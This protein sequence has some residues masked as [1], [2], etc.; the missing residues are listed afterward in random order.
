MPQIQSKTNIYGGII[1]RGRFSG[2]EN[3]LKFKSRLRVA[4]TLVSQHNYVISPTATGYIKFITKYHLCYLFQ[5]VGEQ[6]CPAAAAAATAAACLPGW[7]DIT[8]I[9]FLPHA[10]TEHITDVL[11]RGRAADHT[12][13]SASLPWHDLKKKK[14]RKK[15]DVEMGTMPSCSS[16]ASN[17]GPHLHTRLIA[18]DLHLLAARVCLKSTMQIMYS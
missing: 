9:H 14:K 7:G 3:N 15:N 17:R 18:D 11:C 12:G 10:G 1:R 16:D 13:L 8:K 2:Q 4:I 5:T 6:M